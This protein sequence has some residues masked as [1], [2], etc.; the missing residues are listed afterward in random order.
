MGSSSGKA[1]SASGGAP[2]GHS[3]RRR[4]VQEAEVAT[5]ERREKFQPGLAPVGNGNVFY[6]AFSLETL[7]MRYLR[8][9]IGAGCYGKPFGEF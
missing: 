5:G 9:H 3:S 7:L 4:I 1:R 6:T 2:S 8:I